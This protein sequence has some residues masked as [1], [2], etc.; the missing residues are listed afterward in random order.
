MGRAPCCEKVGLKKGRWTAEEDELL[1]KY[2]L[3]NGEGSWRS[4]PKN[5][6]L[7][8]CGK[9]CRLRW[10]NYLR[11]DLKRGNI[12]KEEEEII[13]QLRSTFG[14]RWSLI[15]THLPGRTDNE[16]KNYWNSHLSRKIYTF[17]KNNDSLPT[18]AIKITNIAGTCKYR[19]GKVSQSAVKKHKGN[20]LMLVA[21]RP[22]KTKSGQTL[23]ETVVEEATKPNN[24]KGCPVQI[25][26]NGQIMGLV[27]TEGPTNT[28]RD[29]RDDSC[30]GSGERSLINAAGVFPRNGDDEEEE[31]WGPYEWLDSEINRLKYALEGET[32][33]LNE[34][35]ALNKEKEE[36][37]DNGSRV[38]MGPDRVASIDQE[39]ESSSCAT[40]WSSS[41]AE[42]GE[43]YICGPSPVNL[44][45][46]EEWYNLSFDWDGT[47]GEGISDDNRREFWDEGDKILLPWLW[48]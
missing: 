29:V 5:A 33:V 9:S 1:T 48:S 12:T 21:R 26:E 32:A 28:I 35:N 15:A 3:A 41:N 23:K 46:D 36:E 25:D 19:G 20:A 39:R 13:V 14:N 40:A 34:N 4:L 11:A 8:R 37:E 22:P 2:I 16:I 31:D 6:G 47:V 44:G 42:S 45:F 43:F 10:I 38:G 27:P 24:D 7:L 18:T 17:C 30:I